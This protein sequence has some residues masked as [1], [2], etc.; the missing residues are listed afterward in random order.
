MHM[1][2]YSGCHS[3]GAF[4]LFS[5][6]SSQCSWAITR[7]GWLTV[8]SLGSS[9]LRLPSPEIT[10]IYL[11]TW[12]ESYRFFFLLTHKSAGATVMSEQRG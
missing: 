1:E 5:D 2:A 12:M 7:L 6:I 11:L 9:P 3:S 10:D 8:E 4:T